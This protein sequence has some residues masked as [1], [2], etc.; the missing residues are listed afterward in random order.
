[1]K[2]SLILLIALLLLCSGCAD[3]LRKTADHAANA[4]VTAR[5]DRAATD[6][7][8]ATSAP[9]TAAPTSPASLLPLLTAR[10][11]TPSDPQN[12]AGRATQRREHSYGVS[13]GTAPHAISAEAQRFFTQRGYPAIVYD[14]KASAKT[15]YLT[16]DC[17]Y[18]N[19]CTAKILDILKE[20]QVPAAFFCTLDH[21]RS[22]PELI[23]RMIREGHIVGNHSATHPDF[24]GLSRTA[25]A[26]EILDCENELRTKFGYFSPYFRFPMG[27]YN[28]NA[29]ELVGELGY[30]S[31]FWSAAYADW[32][33]EAQKGADYARETVL[34]RIHPGAILLLHAVSPDNA[35]ALGD[36]IDEARAEGYEFRALTAYGK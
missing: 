34:A 32:D 29:L 21:I 11:V 25:M 36:I 17:G 7:T 28:E 4:P 23:G 5:D 31:V 9:A 13:D 20:K 19:G 2:K 14:D 10:S 16:F 1:M 24:S 15:L 35:L 8:S 18:E 3:T 6:A 12:T 26:K 27:A 33:P 30:T 22:D